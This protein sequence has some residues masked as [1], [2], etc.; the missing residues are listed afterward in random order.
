[1]RRLLLCLGISAT[2]GGLAAACG[3]PRDACAIITSGALLWCW[4]ALIE[5]PV[6]RALAPPR[7][8]VLEA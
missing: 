1:M 4:M 8:D 6:R 7:P 2:V 5:A 3:L